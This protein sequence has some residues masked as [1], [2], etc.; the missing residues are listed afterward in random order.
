MRLCVFSQGSPASPSTDPWAGALLGGGAGQIRK[1]TNMLLQMVTEYLKGWMV[2][3][4]T[5][6]YTLPT[7]AQYRFD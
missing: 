4:S 6:E 5:P 2:P 1:M 7:R 3:P